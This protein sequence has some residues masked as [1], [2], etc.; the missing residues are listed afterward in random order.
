M[1]KK[2]AMASVWKDSKTGKSVFVDNATGASLEFEDDEEKDI[3]L[4]CFLE[5]CR[6]GK[7]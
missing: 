7:N 1:A 6:E 5:M 4:S 2:K 3:F